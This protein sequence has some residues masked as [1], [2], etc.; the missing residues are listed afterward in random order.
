MQSMSK[1]SAHAKTRVLVIGGG[2]AGVKATLELCKNSNLDVTLLSDHSHFRFYPALYHTAT[3][4]KR[5]GARIRLENILQDTDV[6]FVRGAAKTLNRDT[7]ELVL[8][9]GTK[10]HYDQLLLAL[11][12]ITNYFGIP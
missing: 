3:G 9:D 1:N 11:G 6:K 8:E 5:A 10:L 2:F 12:N 7:K 4:G